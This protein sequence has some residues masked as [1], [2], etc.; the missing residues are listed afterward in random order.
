MLLL[1]ECR[2][3]FEFA[4]LPM[5]L[6]LLA[7]LVPRGDGHAVAVL[8]GLLNTDMSTQPLRQ[9]L[10]FSGYDAHGWGHGRNMGLRE[11][12]MERAQDS[13]LELHWRS[14]RKISLIGWSLGGVIAREFARANPDAVRQVISLGSPL[15]GSP[16]R[17]SNLWEI[18]RWASGRS[19][20]Q[21][22]ERGD[23]PPPV[24]STSI[25]TRGDGVVSWR[26]CIEKN[27]P[28]SDN[29]EIVGASHTGLGFNPLVYFAIGDRL[30]Q[31]EDSWTP[32]APPA[33]ARMWFSSVSSAPEA[34]VARL[35]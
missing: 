24:P 7:G 18:Y 5:S 21:P 26:S 23:A 14:G 2:A 3:A 33:W 28:L 35:P 17:I 4:L 11:G 6:P 8:P 27:A 13:L 12:V 32:F 9:F 10:K 20:V 22:H 15:Y 30:A 29:I 16:D 31:A 25:F 1:L 19:D 34:P